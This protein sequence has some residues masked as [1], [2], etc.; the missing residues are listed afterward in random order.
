PD[1]VEDLVAV[2]RHND[3]P[4]RLVRGNRCCGMPKLELGDLDSVAAYARDNLPELA[5]LA[6]D[7]WDLM[8][9]VPSCTCSSSGN[10]SGSSWRTN[11]CRRSSAPSSTP[12]YT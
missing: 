4:V 7:G 11:R 6:A 1:M 2:L 8:A 10:I 12:S 5:A 3:I 9:P